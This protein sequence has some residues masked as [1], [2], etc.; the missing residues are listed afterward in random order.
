MIVGLCNRVDLSRV[1]SQTLWLSDRS[2]F[3]VL[4]DFPRI[5]VTALKGKEKEKRKRKRMR[6]RKK[7]IDKQKWNNCKHQRCGVFQSRG[8]C[9]RPN[10][11]E[12]RS[13]Y[14]GAVD[15]PFFSITKVSS[16]NSVRE[17]VWKKKKRNLLD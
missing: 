8:S 5:R 15:E 4:F 17:F 7:S 6:E 16:N 14:D 1:M 12:F 11:W 9:S 13:Q 10:D 3:D 2:H